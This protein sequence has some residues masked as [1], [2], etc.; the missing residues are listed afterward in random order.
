[1]VSSAIASGAL[2]PSGRRRFAMATKMLL[3]SHFVEPCG[4]HRNL[5]L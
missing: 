4:S 2:T 1:M 5:T 3:W